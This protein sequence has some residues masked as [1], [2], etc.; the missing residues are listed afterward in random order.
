MPVE[1]HTLAAFV[2]GNLGFTFLFNR[3][4]R[5]FFFRFLR[6]VLVDDFV[7]RIFND[8]FGSE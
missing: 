6:E 3:S 1:L 5:G 4:H 7:E 2:F 8:T